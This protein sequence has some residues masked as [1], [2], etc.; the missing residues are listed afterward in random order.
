MEQSRNARNSGDCN[1]N[2]YNAKM[3]NAG[4]MKLYRHFTIIIIFQNT[5]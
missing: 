1:L 4:A 2:G 5:Q 3:H